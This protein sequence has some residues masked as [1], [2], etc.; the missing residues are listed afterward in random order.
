MDDL[1]LSIHGIPASTGYR[2]D[3]DDLALAAHHA[4]LNGG[5]GYPPPAAAGVGYQPQ[6]QA[7]YPR[8]GYAAPYAA[9]GSPET[10][11]VEREQMET[12]IM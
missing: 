6:H 1:A 4:Q 2:K 9:P 12:E 10:T 7:Y 11:F 8:P 5:G 3:M